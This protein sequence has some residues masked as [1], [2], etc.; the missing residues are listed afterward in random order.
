MPS[1]IIQHARDF[2]NGSHDCTDPAFSVACSV[3]SW[4]ESMHCCT[5]TG[6]LLVS[7][8]LPLAGAALTARQHCTQELAAC[9]HIAACRRC[10]GK[11]SAT[12]DVSAT[13]A[14]VLLPRLPGFQQSNFSAPASSLLRHRYNTMISHTLAVTQHHNHH[15]KCNCYHCDSGKICVHDH[16]YIS[17]KT[18]TVSL[19]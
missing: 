7:C 12:T 5:Y 11:C 10:S 18:T 19:V 14:Q 9:L 1:L 3:H 17:G 15:H 6:V 8:L 16:D 2:Q 4:H 13:N